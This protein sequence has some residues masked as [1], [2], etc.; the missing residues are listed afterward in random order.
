MNIIKQQCSHCN[1][2]KE[3]SEFSIF[4]G[5]RNQECKE[6]RDYH[7]NHYAKTRNRITGY[8]KEYYASHRAEFKKRHFKDSLKRKYKLTLEEYN[9]MIEHQE[10]KCEICG[11]EFSDKLRPHVDHCHKTGVVRGLLCRWCNL[12]LQY[13]DNNKFLDKS[14]EYLNKQVNQGIKSPW[15]NK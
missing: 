12:S 13:I 1:K 3:E 11:K 15:D 4:R 9:V 6:C 10:N 14:L 7:N 2:I 5:K 8:R